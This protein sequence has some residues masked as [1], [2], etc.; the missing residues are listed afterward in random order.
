MGTD[1]FSECFELEFEYLKNTVLL[2]HRFRNGVSTIS[3]CIH[4]NHEQ[5]I[6]KPGG[7]QS[8]IIKIGS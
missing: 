7:N 1:L 6:L 8:T 4:W 5:C 2:A 3:N